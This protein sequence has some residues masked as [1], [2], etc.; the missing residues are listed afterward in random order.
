MISC[1]NSFVVS[2][3]RILIV[4]IASTL[5]AGLQEGLA[6]TSAATG[7]V[8][9]T[10][11]LG[12]TNKPVHDV[13][14]IIIQLRRSAITGDDGV[15]E[16]QNVPAGKYDVVAHMDRVPDVVRTVEVT[17]GKT[18]EAGFQMRLRPA[19][20]AV[21][22]T[23]TGEAETSLKAIQPV[24]T[25]SSTELAEKNVQSLGEALDRE[26]GISKRSFGP[27]TSRPVVRGFDGDRVL[28]LEDG[29]RIGSL[30][31]QSGD[32]AEPIDVLKLEKLE[33]VKG[34][35]T[36]LYGSSAIGGVVNA[37]TGHESAHPGT[38]GYVTGFA[39]S[40]DYHSGGSA[41]IEQG[42]ENWLFWANGGGQR[43]GDYDTPIGRI[44]NSYSRAGN[45]AGGLGYYPKHAFF[46]LDYA[47]DKRRY[48]VPFDPDEPDAEVVFL[49]PRRHSVGLNAG[50]VDRDWF[51]RG[52]QFSF[53]YNNYGH[54]E[55][56]SF[57]E[58]VNT[59]FNNKTFDYRAVFDQQKKGNWSGSFGIWG[60]H[61]YYSVVRGGSSRSAH[62]A[63]C[64]RGLCARRSSITN[65]RVSRSAAG[66]S[67]TAMTRRRCRNVPHP[68]GHSMAFPGLRACGS[69]SGR[70]GPSRQTTA[71]RTALR[72]WKS[73]TTTARIQGMLLSRSAIRISSGSEATGSICR[74][75]MLPAG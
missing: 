64:V 2:I 28:V 75:G 20:I 4:V 21:T 6:Q 24:N 12:D 72:R 30:G 56:N 42:T 49:D 58:E 16:F 19:E 22:V 5:A 52:T 10:V 46:S 47:V 68:P 44:T 3:N 23:A 65:V 66:L 41:G 67:T 57:T 7:A 50:L 54:R 73:Y 43:A 27:G 9:G 13:S 34:P 55:N 33:V 59:L 61:R 74:S 25:L 39:G 17:A 69:R 18:A 70:T 60:L 51:L 15:F 8:R 36:L 48:G 53:R 26:L 11:T 1:N 31:S 45:G 29:N 71:T 35:A 37:I 14:V 40:N 62:L 32:H 38:H 63:E